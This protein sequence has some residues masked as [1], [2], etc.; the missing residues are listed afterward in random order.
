MAAAYLFH[1]AK[2][3]PFVDGNKRTALACALVFLDLN[4]VEIIADASELEELTV[5]VV[6]GNADKESIAD[7]LARP[8]ITSR[9]HNEECQNLS[10]DAMRTLRSDG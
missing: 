9:Q 8:K 5:A 2:N 10:Y 4:G 3:H 7:F 6:T 1:L